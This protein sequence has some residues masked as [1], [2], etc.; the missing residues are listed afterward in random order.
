MVELL[1]KV[2]TISYVTFHNEMEQASVMTD[3]HEFR[4]LGVC[5]VNYFLINNSCG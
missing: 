4:N 3:A 1:L 5:Y 2:L